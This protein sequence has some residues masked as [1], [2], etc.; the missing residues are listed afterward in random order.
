M[1]SVDFQMN[2]MQ[3][4]TGKNVHMQLSVPQLVE[5]VLKP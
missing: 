5:K 4:L 3:L 1:N 2:Y